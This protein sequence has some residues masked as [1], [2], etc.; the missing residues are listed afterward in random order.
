MK[1]K[2]YK[3]IEKFSFVKLQKKRYFNDSV[4]KY[5]SLKLKMRKWSV[6]RMYINRNAEFMYPEKPW[7][8][9]SP[10]AVSCIQHFLV[11]KHDAR[12]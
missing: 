1:I 8:T 10:A 11:V 12:N 9:I 7:K 4:K 6:F 3:K 2:T 5:K